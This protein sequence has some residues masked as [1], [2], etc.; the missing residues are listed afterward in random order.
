[1]VRA[2]TAQLGS[3]PRTSNAA[4][5]DPADAETVVV[6]GGG[7]AGLGVALALRESS[8]RVVIVERDPEPPEIEPAEAFEQWKRPGVVQFRHPHVFFGRLQR[9]LL[10]RHPELHAE[11]KRA[12]FWQLPV[13]EYGLFRT[14]YQAAPEDAGFTQ[15]CGRR[16]TFEYVLQRYVRA[17]PNVRMIHGAEV[18]ELGLSGEGD[19]LRARSIEIKR[20]AERQTIEGD[21]FVDCLGR[22]SPVRA[23]LQQRGRIAKERSQAARIWY[24]SRHYRLHEGAKPQLEEQSGDLDFL[25]Y[26]IVYGERGHFAIGFSV[27]D[28]DAELERAVKRAD[29]FERVCQAIPQ[30]RDWVENAVALTPVMGMGDMHNCWIDF[31][32]RGR[33]LAL[34]LLHAGDSAS[35]TNPFYG[36]GCSAALLSTHLLAE[37][38]LA[39][40]DPLERARLFS[41]RVRAEL[42]PYYDISVAADR[43]FQARS[44]ASR[45]LPVSLANR[46][47]GHGYVTLA[48]PAA[49]EDA[50]VA[51]ALL[52]IQHMHGSQSLLR[53]LKLV[54]RML[55]LAVRRIGRRARPLAAPLPQR[56]EIIGAAKLQG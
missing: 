56:G 24:F 33:P 27:D 4:A 21:L 53:K 22:R 20:G 9:L 18:A 50:G 26:A 43:M 25:R 5:N 37:A 3:Q 23:W 13:S 31:T 46:I 15:F 47:I 55:Y 41:A 17:L 54:A 29:G 19:E 44:A 6:M 10:E 28:T 7:I 11:L 51:R 38:L 16:A 32:T 48:V 34:N 42:L 45:G 14:G 49:F 40:R 52:A 1:M 35:V 30:V 39:T 8:F 12:G 2:V 36:R